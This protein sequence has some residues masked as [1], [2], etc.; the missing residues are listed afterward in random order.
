MKARGKLIK[1]IT[2]VVVSGGLLI[3]GCSYG[4]NR[5]AA[6]D[7]SNDTKTAIAVTIDSKMIDWAP[8]VY[9]D[10]ATSYLATNPD[11]M[12]P[13]SENLTTL[14]YAVSEADLLNEKGQVY[15]F[16]ANASKVPA[17]VGTGI[18]ES[19]VIPRAGEQRQLE[20]VLN[21][22]KQVDVRGYGSIIAQMGLEL[23]DRLYE[24]IK[25]VMGD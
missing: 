22:I 25:Q 13:F 9:V 4:V 7:L 16:G 23:K 14:A 3:G 18:C 19:D 15:M 24:T 8:G 11:A 1:K 2:A 10:V 6:S 5:L 17:D 12:G 20:H 21:S